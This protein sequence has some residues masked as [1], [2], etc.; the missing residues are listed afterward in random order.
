MRLTEILAKL[1]GEGSVIDLD[2]KLYIHRDTA[3]EVQQRL[4][5]MVGDFHHANPES[6]GIN[7]E[8]FLHASQLPKVIFDSLISRL[9]LDGKLTER[10]HRIALPE[11]QEAISLDERKL[12]SD[13]E[14]LYK[15]RCFNPP[16]RQEVIEQTGVLHE[17]LEKALR[18]LIEQE[19]LVRVEN[20]LFFH[21]EAIEKARQILVSFISKEG[22]LESVKFKYLL[23]TTRKFAIPLLD[24]FDRVGV[25]RRVGNTRYLKT[26]N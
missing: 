20:D 13:V 17:K 6:P 4:L 26:Q 22:K 3:A 24:Y 1:V 9:V 12:L 21:A 8:Q 5:K 7:A 25:I 23:D 18:M 19:R 11:H 15:S 14:S 16:T 10:K 2:G